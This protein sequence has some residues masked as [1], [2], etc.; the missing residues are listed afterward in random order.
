MNV[1]VEGNAEVKD[2]AGEIAEDVLAE[3]ELAAGG[4]LEEGRED[5][6]RE[7][8]Q[9]SLVL[10][11]KIEPKTRRVPSVAEQHDEVE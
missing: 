7:E 5:D 2:A 10:G 3:P 8:S 11:C 9:Q 6:V 4:R 1:D